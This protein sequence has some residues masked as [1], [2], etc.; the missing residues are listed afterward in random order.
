[1]HFSCCIHKND[2][3]LCKICNIEI[4]EQEEEKEEKEE[5][6]NNIKENS[7]F[8]SKN[9]NNKINERIKILKLQKIK[10]LDKQFFDEGFFS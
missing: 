1:M 2:K 8:F 6:D 4:D 9:F 5:K 3:V 10:R 7:L